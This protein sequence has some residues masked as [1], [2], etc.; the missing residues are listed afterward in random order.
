MTAPGFSIRR[1]LDGGYTLALRG[2]LIFDITPDAF[3]YMRQFWAVFRQE[4]S[5]LK[6]RLGQPFLEALDNRR[7]WTLDQ[8]SPFERNREWDPKPDAIAL[9]TALTNL[10]AT[11]PLLRD[12]GVAERW[13]G[14]IDATPDAVPVISPVNALPGF[15][16]ATGFSGH[17]FGIG[18]GAGHLAADLVTG[19]RPIVDPHP[20][21]YAR[22][23]D[24]TK[25]VPNV[26]L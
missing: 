26:G 23:I 11:Y 24:G 22:M 16:V 9:E 19:K 13:A 5:N 10:K 17:G 12:I 2:R 3:R 21:R 4:G 25:L 7:H 14:M 18:P 1:R 8:T 15:Y 6:L 20:F